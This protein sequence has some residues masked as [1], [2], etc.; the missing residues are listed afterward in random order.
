MSSI[1]AINRGVPIL[2]IPFF[3]DQKSNIKR[4][5]HRGYALSVSYREINEENFEKA[6]AE[7]LNNPKY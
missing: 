7:L 6:L 4:A 1:E 2:G 3:S 5:V